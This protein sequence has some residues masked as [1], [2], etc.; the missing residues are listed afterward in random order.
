MLQAAG[1][2]SF[3]NG[4]PIFENQSHHNSKPEMFREK[5]SSS[6]FLSG[7]ISRKTGRRTIKNDVEQYI[8]CN[9]NLHDYPETTLEI[10]HSKNVV[11]EEFSDA[12]END[13][14]IEQKCQDL[15]KVEANKVV[16]QSEQSSDLS[17]RVDEFSRIAFPVAFISFN[18]VYW[19]TFM[20]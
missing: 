19:C 4:V 5:A 8:A 2:S 17:V 13:Q 10:E 11:D 15:K 7:L 3:A 12:D 9:N 1:E 20:R 6:G 14:A 16:N 18:V